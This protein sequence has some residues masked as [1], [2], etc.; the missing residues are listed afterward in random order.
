M[1]IFNNNYNAK[2]RLN[3]IFDPISNHRHIVV[4][5]A[6]T[7]LC[8]IFRKPIGIPPSNDRIPI[9]EEAEERFGEASSLVHLP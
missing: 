4:I 5:E 8:K 2:L 7:R 1:L 6:F 3:L 9:V